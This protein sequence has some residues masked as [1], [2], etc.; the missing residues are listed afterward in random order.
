MK[1]RWQVF[2]YLLLYLFLLALVMEF[3]VK[4]L[5]DGKGIVML[6]TGAFLLTL[7]F[8]RKGVKKGELLNIF[9]KKAAE[10]G[11][12]QTFLLLFVRLSDQ[13]GSEELLPDVALCFRPMLYAFCVKF[14]FETDEEKEEKSGE[15]S[16]REQPEMQE[17][18]KLTFE[19]C[20]SAGLTKREAE[21][22]LLVCQGYANGEIAEKLVISETTVKKH[23]SNIFE[24]T[25]I[26]KREELQQYI[27]T[28]KSFVNDK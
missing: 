5:I 17:R 21:I 4:K 28:N 15:K 26:K 1:R 25:G 23:V 6:L 22:A 7:P 19:N 3:D 18:K 24:K 27:E 16:G 2:L 13:K 9:G 8:C 11:L 10:A 12:I 20:I 14:T